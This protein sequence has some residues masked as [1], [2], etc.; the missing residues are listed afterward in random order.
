MGPKKAGT[1]AET[2]ESSKGCNQVFNWVEHIH[3]VPRKIELQLYPTQP[4]PLSS[5]MSTSLSSTTIS[6]SSTSILSS[7]TSKSSSSYQHRRHQRQHQWEGDIC[8]HL[9]MVVSLKKTC[10][11]ERSSSR[12]KSWFFS[13]IS[14]FFLLPMISK[15]QLIRWF[16]TIDH[17]SHSLL[18]SWENCT[19]I[20]NRLTS[21]RLIRD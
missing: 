5:S 14:L 19:L 7:S 9:I 12:S 16:S 17:I 18:K 15:S 10:R 8:V 20:Q 2:K 3:V 4:P 13:I 6:S 1:S 21:V 11:R